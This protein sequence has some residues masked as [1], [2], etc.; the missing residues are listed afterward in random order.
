MPCM[1]MLPHMDSSRPNMNLLLFIILS[2]FTLHRHHQ[3]TT[4]E[5]AESLSQQGLTYTT[6]TPAKPSLLPTAYTLS[7]VTSTTSSKVF[8]SSDRTPEVPETSSPLTF[9]ASESP[10]ASTEVVPTPTVS[11]NNL[12]FPEQKIKRRPLKD[13]L[14]NSEGGKSLEVLTQPT[15]TTPKLR[16]TPSDLI[17]NPVVITTHTQNEKPVMS[18]SLVTD[19]SPEMTNETIL[20][21]EDST[22]TPDRLADTL[23]QTP[24]TTQQSVGETE[25][26]RLTHTPDGLVDA[27]VETPTTQQ[28]V[29]EIQLSR[30]TAKDKL[31]RLRIMDE[32]NV[33]E[34]SSQPTSTQTIQSSKDLFELFYPNHN[35]TS[36]APLSPNTINHTDI[37]KL[38]RFFLF[39]KKEADTSESLAKNLLPEEAKILTSTEQQT[40]RPISISKQNVT[41]LQF[42]RELPS[43]PIAEGG[44]QP[45]LNP[46]KPINNNRT[47]QTLIPNNYGIM[48]PSNMSTLLP[49]ICGTIQTPSNVMYDSRSSSHIYSKTIS[50]VHM[51]PGNTYGSNRP[52]RWLVTAQKVKILSLEGRVRTTPNAQV[53]GKGKRW[54]F[55]M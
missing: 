16:L 10:V 38:A 46:S 42:P 4:A 36:L 29:D 14:E 50:T 20:L 27:S 2:H 32:V 49:S 22:N 6:A 35:P 19:D 52:S 23:V 54:S 41:I 31:Q 55:P 26:I 37:N 25:T 53:N 28:I 8:E 21:I 18:E 47:D 3:L 33:R 13:T 45:V 15:V 17:M 44:F 40:L 11:P 5:E 51:L 9:A 12:V 30:L 24:V 7:P 1:R 43:D 48:F 39:N 34:T